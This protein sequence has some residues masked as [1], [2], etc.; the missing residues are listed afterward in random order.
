M[1]RSPLFGNHLSNGWKKRFFLQWSRL[2]LGLEVLEEV[3]RGHRMDWA[4]PGP[5]SARTGVGVGAL[6]MSCGC[7][8]HIRERQLD[9]QVQK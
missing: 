8:T 2:G 6:L 5:L 3:G 4:L 1:G 7:R 9:R